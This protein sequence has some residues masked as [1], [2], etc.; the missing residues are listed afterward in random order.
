MAS[1]EELQVRE[2]DVSEQPFSQ[3]LP[4]YQPA[5]GVLDCENKSWTA[6][7][8]ERK[9]QTDNAQ[10]ALPLG[11][12]LIRDDRGGDKEDGCKYIE[13]Y[14]IHVEPEYR[15]HGLE[16]RLINFLKLRYPAIAVYP[17]DDRQDSIFMQCD[18]KRVND[19]LLLYSEYSKL[20][21]KR[22]RYMRF[23][24]N[25]DDRANEDFATFMD[26]LKSLVWDHYFRISKGRG[27][28]VKT[29]TYIE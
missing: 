18:F 17:S 13:L 19:E 22:P 11:S 12:C 26:R 23:N 6:Y 20:L 9:L 10:N 28:S 24:N 7:I 29:C 5:V 1:S 8:I 21:E 2:V 4:R 25:I 27:H 16:Y 15:D 3:F 14:S